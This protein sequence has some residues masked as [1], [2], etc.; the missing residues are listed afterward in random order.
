LAPLPEIILIDTYGINP[1]RSYSRCP[2]KTFKSGVK[3]G[4][5]VEVVPIQFDRLGA[6]RISPNVGQCLVRGEVIK[7]EDRKFAAY[8][9]V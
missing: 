4:G 5:D 9:L 1:Q 7:G 3:V 8:L 2:T 6:F